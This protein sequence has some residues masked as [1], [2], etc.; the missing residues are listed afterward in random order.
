MYTSRFA[1]AG[2]PDFDFWRTVTSHGWYDLA[3][4]TC[5]PVRR[6]LGLILT[7]PGG[8]AVS[9]TAV[10]SGKGV[11]VTVHS[12]VPLD[13]ADRRSLKGQIAT[14]LRLHEDFRPL[15]T[16]ARRLPGWR[17]IAD[18]KCGRLLRAPT[19]FEDAVKMI[20]TT[21]CTWALT[22]IMVANLV[23]EFGVPAADGRHAFPTPQAIAGSQEGFLRRH[24]TTGY[25]SPYIL[26]LSRR[27]AAGKLDVESW[28]TPGIPEEALYREMQTVKG[29]GEYAA[30]NLLKL[31]GRYERLGLDS[32]VRQRFARIHHHG[33]RVSDD[34]IGRH[35]REYGEWRGLFFW[36]EM[37][38]D[39][40]DD[41]FPHSD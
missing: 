33:R 32:W 31:V 35:Y 37:T 4:F 11:G 29:I 24:C 25:R 9:S 7:A 21:N 18:T 13:T 34:T 28:R 8:R 12:S 17:W 27:V 30:G 2:R 5:D 40:H 23:H 10:K 3:P 38:R 41:K 1:L 20:C 15:H 26:E 36:L 19:V 39:W 22:K 14:C 16:H 6:T